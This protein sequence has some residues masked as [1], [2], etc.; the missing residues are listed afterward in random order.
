MRA[1]DEVL[2]QQ[3]IATSQALCQVCRIAS[4]VLSEEY[5]T[6][7]TGPMGAVED[8]LK[9][10]PTVTGWDGVFRESDCKFEYFTPD[11]PVAVPD[12][13]VKVIHIPTGLNVQSYSSPSQEEN[14]NRA[15][16]ALEQRVADNG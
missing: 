8:V 10:C 3:L 5:E 4:N 6:M 1:S 12:Q 7:I 14:R 2:F 13:G 11:T 9:Q 16:R 15:M